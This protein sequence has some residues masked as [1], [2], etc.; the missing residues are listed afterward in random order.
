MGTGLKMENLRAYGIEDINLTYVSSWYYIVD[1][2]D[3]N[4]K[5]M[6]YNELKIKVN[7]SELEQIQTV[8]IE[9][10]F[11]S[12][13]IDDPDDARDIMEHPET[14]KY[15]YLNDEIASDLGR[16]PVITLYFEDNEEGNAEMEKAVSLIRNHAEAI[17]RSSA[18]D[19]SEWLYKWQEFFK[20]SRV[21]DRIVVKP[22]WEEYIAKPG[23]LVIEMDPGMAFGSGLHGTTSMCIKALEQILDETEE[24][25]SGTCKV[26]DVGC[27]TG[28]LAISAALL[29]A[30]ECLGIDI[31]PDAVSVAKENIEKNGLSGKIT[32]Q[33]GDLTEGVDYKADI[34][35]ANLMA[36]L[37]IRLSPAAYKHVNENGWY[38]TS[39][40]LDIKEEV[41]C[42]AIRDAGFRIRE[43]LHDG[44]WR[45]VIAC[46]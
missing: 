9:N 19:D 11:V 18:G 25:T 23:D 8:L 32:A 4:G 16:L 3:G 34:V 36:D 31:D 33:Y 1:E 39:G 43:V 20:P 5:K 30:D 15:D 6:K 28:I 10:G 46:K 14:Y 24:K 35:V 44:E 12:M 17:K 2:I 42:Q 27:G 29:G 13:M 7:K 45:A 40:I 38:I 37:V 41:V 22:S 21:G 26:L